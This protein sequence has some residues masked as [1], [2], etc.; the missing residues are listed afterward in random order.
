MVIVAYLYLKAASWG[1]MVFS[2]YLFSAA[3]ILRPAD[4]C[5]EELSELINIYSLSDA[6]IQAS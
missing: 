1:N 2:V 4:S 3:I 6:D 5:Y